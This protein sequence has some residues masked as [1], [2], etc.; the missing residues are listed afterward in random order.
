VLA[1]AALMSVFT[2]MPTSLLAEISLRLH[3]VDPEWLTLYQENL[4]TTAGQIILAAFTVVLVAPLAEEIIFRGLLQ[5]VTATL[6]GPVPAILI[7]ALVFGIVHGEPW[8]LFGLIGVGIMLA[9]VFAATGSVT[10]CWVAHG[11]HNAISLGVML[12]GHHSPEGPRDI[13]PQTIT[14]WDWILVLASIAGLLVVGKFLLA[15][16]K[17]GFRAHPPEGTV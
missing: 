4:P 11:V 13:V 8:F 10:A 14:T 5:K 16:G 6:W 12:L 9:F 3:P 17:V 15:K 7:S 2:V 1:A